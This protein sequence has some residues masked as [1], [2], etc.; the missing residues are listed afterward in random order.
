MWTPAAVL[1]FA[2]GEHAGSAVRRHTW[3]GHSECAVVWS[4]L[5]LMHRRGCCC[6]GRSELYPEGAASA[7]L[8]VPLEQ[9][10]DS[11]AKL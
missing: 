9:N 6:A 3:C 5:R 2:G 1:A 8:L 7:Q 11:L 10:R 4:P